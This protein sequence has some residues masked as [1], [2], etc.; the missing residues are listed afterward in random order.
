M[1]DVVMS[2]LFVI[3]ALSP[4]DPMPLLLY[5]VVEIAPMLLIL[6]LIFKE[7]MPQL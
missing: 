1:P 3:W 6:A 7:V 5:P 4:I 2:P